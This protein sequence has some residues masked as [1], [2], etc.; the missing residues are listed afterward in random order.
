MEHTKLKKYLEQYSPLPA[1]DWQF[2]VSRLQPRTFQKKDLILPAGAVENYVNFIDSG[3]IRYFVIEEEKDIT[4]EIA[5]ENS[6]AT[7]YDSFLTRMPV[8]YAAEALTDV[9]LWSIGYDHLQEMYAL[10]SVGDRVGRLAA[11]QLYIRKN[12]RQMSFLKDDAGARYTG[13]MNDHPHLLQHVPLK[14]L[15]SYIGITP[16]A[17][18]RIR[19]RMTPGT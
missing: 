3:I 9:E 2:F 8:Q 10:T 11:E 13:L 18:S 1:T 14:Y 4:F 6:F 5:F 19:R 7:A 16:Q 17:L 15:A 12:K